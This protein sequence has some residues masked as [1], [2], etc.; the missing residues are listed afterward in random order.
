ML[1]D[2]ASGIFSR[3]RRV[4]P[5]LNGTWP[6]E[7]S[8]DSLVYAAQTGNRISIRPADAMKELAQLYENLPEVIKQIQALDIGRDV[9]NKVLNHLSGIGR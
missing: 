9:R 4:M 5:L 6:K 2:G 3:L 8:P 1:L 7:W